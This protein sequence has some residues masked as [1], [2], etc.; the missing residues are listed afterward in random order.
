MQFLGENFFQEWNG[1]NASNVSILER[2]HSPYT[3]FLE[4]LDNGVE[5]LGVKWIRRNHILNAYN[6][7]ARTLQGSYECTSS[8]LGTSWF[9]I[10]WQQ[11]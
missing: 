5:M 4:C 7:R 10:L 3:N 8:N 2:N 1:Y 9:S 6:V 11:S